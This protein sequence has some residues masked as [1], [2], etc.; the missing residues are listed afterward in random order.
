MWAGLYPSETD[1]ALTERA[2]NPRPF[3]ASE[4]SLWSS[5][6]ALIGAPL[7]GAA[8][9]VNESLRLVGRISS[10]RIEPDPPERQA[11]GRSASLLPASMLD[12][13]DADRAASRQ[14]NAEIAA[15]TDE[16][17]K[18]AATYWKPNPQ[19]AGFVQN[20]LHEAGRVI[21]KAVGYGAAAGPV[22]M[23]VGTSVDEGATGYLSLRDRGVDA[24]TAVQGG[25]VRAAVTAASMAAPAVGST[26]ARSAG[27]V[28]A[29]GPGLFVGEQIASRA[30]LERAGYQDIAA[31]FDPWDPAG[32]AVS[33][34]PGALVAGVVHRS[35][36]R[37]AAAMTPEQVQGDAALQ[38]AAD[39]PALVEAAHVQY[40]QDMLDA[41]MLGD[42]ADPAARVSHAQALERARQALDEGRPVDVGDLVVNPTRADALR[43]EVAARVIE[44][45]RRQEA[46]ARLEDEPETAPQAMPRTVQDIDAAV[47]ASADA[48]AKQRR[49][50]REFAAREDAQQAQAQGRPPRTPE[51]LDATAQD[52]LNAARTAD[53]KRRWGKQGPQEPPPDAAAGQPA[54]PVQRAQRI[55]TDMPGLKVRM[56]ETQPAQSAADVLVSERQAAV[57]EAQESK[58][59]FDAAVECFINRGME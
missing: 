18:G 21:T 43:A 19:T 54:T 55:A 50:F 29:T 45:Q 58:T 2:I 33:L 11:V 10:A 57:R 9:G 44:Q 42:R 46:M 5:A 7:M 47:A 6:G 39:T 1:R 59:M 27:I 20:L 22:G 37:K 35:R 16:F 28:A 12:R 32:L 34:V 23:V 26:L 30:I 17:F 56:D 49:W 51:E 53:A 24:T 41:A 36:A 8:Q 13:M 48:E 52:M 40:G 31:E 38:Q 15:E 3:L 4:P 25:L 14:R